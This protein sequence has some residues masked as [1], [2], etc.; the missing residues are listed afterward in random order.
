MSRKVGDL[1][2]LAALKLALG[3][4][5]AH[6]GFSHI[7]DDD[8]ARTVISELFAHSPKLDPSGTSW[9]PFP[10]WITG[11]A[12]MILGRTIDVARGVA[13][14]LS[15]LS[16][17][18][19]YLALRAIGVARV[20]A[21]VG[22]ALGMATPW[23]AWLG[24][25]AVPEGY[26]G[27]LVAAGAITLGDARVR[28]WAALCLLA[29]ALSR[30]E[31]WPVCAVFAAVITLRTVRN[32][33]ERRRAMPWVTVAMAISGPLA[34][35]AWNLHAHGSATHFLTRVAAYR[36]AIGAGGEPLFD[37]VLAY[38]F[39]VVTGAPDVAVTA[40]AGF[41]AL[42]IFSEMRVRWSMPL[43]A[44]LS[45]VLFLAYGDAR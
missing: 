20:S 43:A 32:E 5:L 9:L 42:Y 7:S 15:A 18:P 12:M 35:M 21:L 25:A 10:F 13:F 44:M 34:W 29:A 22:V 8:Y 27:A 16:V 36:Q 41:I 45:V 6:Q 1:A 11:A 31:A 33:S 24:A 40:L 19:V 37:R 39:A 4:W 26:A 30:Y 3:L 14:A 2:G 28:P 23:N 17:V 38:P